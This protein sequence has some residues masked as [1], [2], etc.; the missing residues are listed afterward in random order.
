VGL[1][2]QIVRVVCFE[3]VLQVFAEEGVTG[4]EKQKGNLAHPVSV[5]RGGLEPLGLS[6][7][8]RAQVLEATRQALNQV[9]NGNLALA[10]R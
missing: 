1:S 2:T 8:V 4:R 7:T 3:A 6:I 9:V 10:P 5:V